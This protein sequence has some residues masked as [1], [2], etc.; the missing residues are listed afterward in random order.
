M[1]HEKIRTYREAK[2]ISEEEFARSVCV[3]CQTVINWENG[4]LLPDINMLY[5][6][7]DVL[8]ISVTD[9]T[10][11]NGEYAQFYTV[12]QT[13]NK[14][15]T[16]QKSTRK[17]VIKF[18]CITILVITMTYCLLFVYGFMGIKNAKDNLRAYVK[19]DN[20]ETEVNPEIKPTEVIPMN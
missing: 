15:H 9:L 16:A 2:G 1:L 6:I 4:L 7:A 10:G 12:Y 20:V 18:I 19:I 11:T 14:Q 5:K 8:D 13:L 3:D 17:L